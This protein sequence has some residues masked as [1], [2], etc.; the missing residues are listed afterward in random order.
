MRCPEM[1]LVASGGPV[2]AGARPDAASMVQQAMAYVEA[3]PG[4]SELQYQVGKEYLRGQPYLLVGGTFRRDGTPGRLLG[5]FFVMPSRHG[6]V[7][8]FWSDARGAQMA[9]RV[10]RSLRLASS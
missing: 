4:I 5:A 10:M 1:A 6:H 9:S 7:L 2:P 3:T 8:C